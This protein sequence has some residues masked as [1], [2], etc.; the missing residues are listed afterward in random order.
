MEL[1][2]E[3]KQTLRCECDTKP[4][5]PLG[6]G[7][8]RGRNDASSDSGSN[9]RRTDDRTDT[10]KWHD[11]NFKKKWVM[12]ISHY[13]SL[14]LT[15]RD[16][17]LPAL[18]GLAKAFEF[19]ATVNGVA[20]GSYDAGLWSTYL[21]ESLLWYVDPR[22]NVGF[23]RTEKYCAPTWSWASIHGQV[24]WDTKY[25]IDKG[26]KLISIGCIPRSKD[27]FG[28]LSGGAMVLCANIVPAVWCSKNNLV[29]LPID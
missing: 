22:R 10:E 13:T 23:K 20:L 19:Q 24:S 17:I 5:L 25:D 9:S 3:C 4:R 27:I 7:L 12:I 11:S 8:T 29:L 2:F 16:D 26:F 6:A 28:A 15:D 14:A 18:S 1:V 21:P